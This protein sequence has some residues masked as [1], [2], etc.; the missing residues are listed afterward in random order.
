[1]SRLWTRVVSAG[2]QTRC[3]ESRRWELV[4]D[5]GGLVPFVLVLS[6]CC[7]VSMVTAQVRRL[8]P[9]V[10]FTCTEAS[11]QKRGGV[12]QAPPLQLLLGGG[13]V[14]VVLQT[15]HVLHMEPW[16]RDP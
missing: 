3:P 2:P 6:D 4:W 10:E 16:G 1:M 5:P 8:L 7:S 14:A 15:P 11:Q 13:D 9:L 12:H